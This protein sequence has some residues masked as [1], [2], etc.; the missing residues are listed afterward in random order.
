MTK[1]VGLHFQASVLGGAVILVLSGCRASDA[2]GD[3]HGSGGNAG[4]GTPG[5]GGSGGAGADA[6]VADALA[7]TDAGSVQGDVVTP[8]SNLADYTVSYR[9][10]VRVPASGAVLSYDDFAAQVSRLDPI[11]A[12][13]C[14]VSHDAQFQAAVDA[15]GGIN[16]THPVDILKDLA[17]HRSTV[18]IFLPPATT[19][20]RPE[21]RIPRIRR[22]PP[23]SGLTWWD[24][25]R[26]S[27]SSSPND[28][29][30][31]R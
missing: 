5:S 14:P 6:G 28:M 20:W 10:Q 15:L 17:S 9:S 27:R 30:F 4:G 16:W 31:S 23:S 7:G 13:R 19:Q 1:R 18:G 2:G 21:G 22:R 11:A 24:I 3:T 12:K 26:T 29:G 8:P 25:K